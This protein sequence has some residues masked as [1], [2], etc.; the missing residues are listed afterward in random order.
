MSAFTAPE[1]VTF[2]YPVGR[3]ERPKSC[4]VCGRVGATHVTP[5][6]HYVHLFCTQRCKLTE[7]GTQIEREEP[8]LDHLVTA[9]LVVFVICVLFALGW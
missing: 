1:G 4:A 6:G 8:R 9:L 2:A 3:F 5:D 7:A